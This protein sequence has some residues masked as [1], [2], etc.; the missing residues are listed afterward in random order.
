MF[1]LAAFA[2]RSTHTPTASVYAA[3]GEIENDVE[4]TRQYEVYSTVLPNSKKT[5]IVPHSHPTVHHSRCCDAAVTL[6]LRN[7]A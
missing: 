6:G 5:G 4:G 1:F 7:L 2:G 3:Y